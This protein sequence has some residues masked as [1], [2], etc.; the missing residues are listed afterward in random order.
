M[1]GKVTSCNIFFK[2]ARAHKSPPTQRDLQSL[3]DLAGFY[4]RHAADLCW[5]QPQDKDNETVNSAPTMRGHSERIQIGIVRN[6]ST[7]YNKQSLLGFINQGQP[8]LLGHAPTLHRQPTLTPALI[9]LAPTGIV[10]LLKTQVRTKQNKS[11]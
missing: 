6:S 4:S 3:W 1:K 5:H 7:G 8:M 2:A 10:P 9:L 11:R